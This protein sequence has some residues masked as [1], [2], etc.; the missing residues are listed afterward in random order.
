M[1]GDGAQQGQYAMIG[2]EAARDEINAAGGING[3]PIKLVAMDD[4]GDPAEA[5]TVAQRLVDDKTVQVVVGHMW[6]SATLA[7]EPIYIKA[8]MPVL[9][10]TASNVTVTHSG[11]N[12]LIRICLNDAIQAPQMA[13]LLVNN[14]KA[15]KIAVFYANDDYGRGL[16][17]QA[18]KTAQ[19]LG[20]KVV[21]EAPYKPNI[22]KDFTVQLE[23]AVA[24]G[25]DSVFLGSQQAEGGL[26][27][28]QASQAGIFDK[29]PTFVGN[30]GMLYQLFLDRVD[31][32]AEEHIWL[33]APY[34]VFSE[35][36]VVANFVKMF[37]EKENSLPSETASYSYDALHMIAD[38]YNAGATR[39]TLIAKIK[40]MTFTDLV[41]SDNVSFDQNGDRNELGM[42]AI[43]VK[44]G[45]FVSANTKIDTTNVTFDIPK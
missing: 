5:A 39:E 29:I 19:A 23:A 8:G 12:N 25:A 27:V 41:V 34:D 17:D 3:Q 40:T 22:D 15:T 21:Y 6:S 33:A 1:T 4:K 37:M 10:P 32:T 20:A 9:T 11:F 26:I 44:D 43:R 13:A 2:A 18:K 24:A 42:F 35:R 31:K 30:A 36:P 14:L 28:S 45:K 38:A 16:L 7:A